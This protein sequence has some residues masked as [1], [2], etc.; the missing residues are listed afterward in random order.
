MQGAVHYHGYSFRYRCFHHNRIGQRSSGFQSRQELAKA[1]AATAAPDAEAV[2][3]DGA[4]AVNVVQ[5]ATNVAADVVAVG[6]LVV[7]LPNARCL[8]I[9][10]LQNPNRVVAPDSVNAWQLCCLGPLPTAPTLQV[11]FR[12]PDRSWRAQGS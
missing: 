11:P 8:G 10:A 1:A 9:L 7:L 5:A 2:A 12:I 3:V 4:S 6:L